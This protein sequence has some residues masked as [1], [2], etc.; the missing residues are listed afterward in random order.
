VS[1][2][3]IITEEYNILTGWDRMLQYHFLVIDSKDDKN[4]YNNLADTRNVTGSYGSCR[5]MT[6]QQVIDRLADYNV[7]LPRSLYAKLAHDQRTN[8]GA[9]IS[10]HNADGT[11]AE[12]VNVD[13]V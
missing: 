13:R 5:G 1:Q 11:D 4:V 7:T 6:L 8:V 9:E 12:A 10:Y 3:W 2:R